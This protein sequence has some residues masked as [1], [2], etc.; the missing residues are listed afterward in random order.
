[1]GA[2]RPAN[3]P[4]RLPSGRLVRTRRHWPDRIEA[5][6]V[7]IKLERHRG[8]RLRTGLGRWPTLIHAVGEVDDERGINGSSQQP[9][10]GCREGGARRAE[11]A[12]RYARDPGNRVRR[13]VHAGAPI[14][15]RRKE[16]PSTSPGPPPRQPAGASIG[17]SRPQRPEVE[18]CQRAGHGQHEHPV[19]AGVG[20]PALVEDVR[21]VPVRG[22]GPDHR[23]HVRQGEQTAAAS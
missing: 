2:G 22:H 21:V 19:K 3:V 14:Q 20:R 4:R 9:T 23:D 8:P 15:Q 17:R 1:M 16:R 10:S 12:G 18:T 13:V 11:Q 5:G 7:G 6:S